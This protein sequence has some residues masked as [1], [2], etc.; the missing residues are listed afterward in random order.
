MWSIIG[1]LCGGLLLGRV[2]RRMDFLKYA[3]KAISLTIYLMLFVL[4]LSIGA[5]ENIIGN[6]GEIGLLSLSFAVAGVAGSVLLASLVYRFFYSG[7]P[8]GG[9]PEDGEAGKGGSALKGSLL[10]VGVFLTGVL[11]GYFSLINPGFLGD[12]ASII[13][14]HV[15]MLLVGI[16]IGR[17]PEIM[18]IAGSIDFKILLL[19]LATIAGTLLFT[20]IAGFWSGK[21][22]LTDC[23]AVGSGF[24]YYSLSSVLIS[25]YK[26]AGIG[27]AAAAELAA[28]ALLTNVFREL[29]T[30]LGAPLLY[31]ISP[32]APIASAGVTSI[33]V[34]LPVILKA[35]GNSLLPFSIIH[36]VIVDFSSPF[37]VILFCSL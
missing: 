28:I 9:Q 30:L 29:I 17:D 22:S 4:G 3:G 25:E 14:L 12:K 27:A 8:R 26:V 34:A 36:G 33:D 24:G 37:F 5:D 15:L 32:F 23:L 7:L 19:P 11:C 2:L 31:K 1:I 13:I 16:S 6:F 35:G 20:A 18:A 10:T 21:W